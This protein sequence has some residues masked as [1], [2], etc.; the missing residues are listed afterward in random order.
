MKYPIAE[1]F[2]S[3]QGE[4][5]FTGTPMSFVRFIG[6]SVGQKVC[7][8]CDTDFDKQY[9]ALGGGLFTPLELASFA[10]Q[11]GR[12]LLTGGEPCD[13]DLRPLI[14]ECRKLGLYILVE[15][16]GTKNPTWLEEIDW[17]CVSPKPGYLPVVLERASELKVINTGLGAGAGWPTVEHAVAWSHRQHNVYLQ[18]RN[19][20]LSVDMQ[21]LQDTLDIVMK[22]PT[23]KLSVQLH[24]FLGAR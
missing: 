1:K 6:C 13:R 22:N 7:T 3:I 2:H 11:T 18:P 19:D 20:K 21:S 9:P 8:A 10:A 5:R 4:G 15:T 12:I 14:D 24:K 23:L 17:L 16:S